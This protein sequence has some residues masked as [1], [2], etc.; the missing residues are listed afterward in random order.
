MPL[1]GVLDIRIQCVYA[2]RLG[3]DWLA[4]ALDLA[5]STRGPEDRA[6]YEPGP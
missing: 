6:K 2:A 5:R 1:D 4:S 3:I